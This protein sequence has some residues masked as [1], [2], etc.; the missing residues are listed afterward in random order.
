MSTVIAQ[1]SRVLELPWETVFV[2]GGGALEESRIHP[3][4]Q[5]H[6]IAQVNTFNIHGYPS[7]LFLTGDLRRD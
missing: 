1:C 7:S 3:F 4:F 6:P 2:F 5:N